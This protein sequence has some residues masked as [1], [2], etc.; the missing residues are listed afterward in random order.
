MDFTNAVRGDVQVLQKM[1]S[2]TRHVGTNVER[3]NKI[4]KVRH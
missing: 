1:I 3:P 4:L 2:N